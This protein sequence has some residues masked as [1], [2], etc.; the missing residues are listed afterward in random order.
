[1]WAL[2]VVVLGALGLV[3][4]RELVVARV[5]TRSGGAAAAA[6]GVLD[7]AP[8]TGAD[9]AHTIDRLLEAL[10][11]EGTDEAL[12]VEPMVDGAGG[13]G[14]GA[15]TARPSGPPLGPVPQSS[16]VLVTEAAVLEL[17][18]NPGRVPRGAERAASGAL[19]AGI[20][21][22]GGAALGIGWAPGD[23]L[24]AVGGTPVSARRD[25][26]HLALAARARGDARLGATVARL[27]PLGVRTYE[28]VVEMPGP[29]A[30]IPPSVIPPSVSGAPIQ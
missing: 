5:L 21:V 3:V 14:G 24:I 2:V 6:R 4:L 13:G 17:A 10:L 22:L 15:P 9:G 19:P 12:T 7:G 18:A 11:F 23:R 16:T 25:V 30:V 26:V 8:A 27:T 28:V 20:E 29:G 1:M